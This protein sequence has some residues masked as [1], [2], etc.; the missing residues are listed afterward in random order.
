MFQR[1]IRDSGMSETKLR[2][3]PKK[4]ELRKN[5]KKTEFFSP[6]FKRKSKGKIRKKKS[7]EN[8]NPKKKRKY[9]RNSKGTEN[10]KSTKASNLFGNYFEKYFLKISKTLNLN[11]ERELKRT[12]LLLG[13]F[14]NKDKI[15]MHL[16]SD[17]AYLVQSS[18][19]ENTYKIIPQQ[20]IHDKIRNENRVYNCCNCNERFG[21]PQKRRSCKH[22]AK[23]VLN[24]F[25]SFI[26]DFLTRTKRET[27]KISLG[28]LE[29][30]INNFKITDK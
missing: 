10:N 5:P 9:F 8:Q 18:D 26:Y 6:T 4:T 1:N 22:C 29:E 25:E 7:E 19:G 11:P 13:I 15:K 12:R 2:K 28:N 16:D 21:D 24:N 17:G 27:F 3:N 14:E 30:K 23:L 20:L